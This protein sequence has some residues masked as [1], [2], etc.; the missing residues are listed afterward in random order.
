M[1]Y[2]GT[3]GITLTNHVVYSAGW[4]N[5]L[6]QVVAHVRHLYPSS[7]LIGIAFSLGSNI[8]VK[9]IG[10]E[11]SSTPLNAVI[12]ISNPY[13][14]LAC[15]N[16]LENS[17][18][19]PYLAKGCKSLWKS[20]STEISDFVTANNILIDSDVVQQCHTL[21][22]YDSLVTSKLFGFKTVDEYYGYS[23]CVNYFSGIS[24]PTFFISAI[25]DPIIN[26]NTIPVGLCRSLQNIAL[27]LTNR[28]GHCAF[29]EGLCPT[30]ISWADRVILEISDVL[31]KNK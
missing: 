11:G 5:D 10:E 29:L 15:S 31:T 3:C 6:R 18:Y 24:I 27:I 20:K 9:Y 21:K 8:M 28:G 2:R 17:V 23:G 25:D 30:G 26:P 13:D 7:F 22:E 19:S 1:N 14:L 16:F 12:S 4:T